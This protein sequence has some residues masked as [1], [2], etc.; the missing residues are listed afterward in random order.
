[1]DCLSLLPIDIFIKI[2]TYISFNDVKV[3][4]MTNKKLHNYCTNYNNRWKLLIYNTF[5][6]IDDYNNILK[7]VQN[8]LDCECD[9]LVYTKLIEY[10]DPIT[11]LMI[12]YRQNN[13][14]FDS[15]NYNAFQRFLSLFLLGEKNIVANYLNH[16][17]NIYISDDHLPILD[18]LNDLPVE[19][20]VL[21]WMLVEMASEGCLKG[22]KYLVSKGADSNNDIAC[23]CASENGHL[24]VV[25]Y[26]VQNGANIHANNNSAL[27]WA[28]QNGH[29]EI[30]KFLHK[31]GANIHVQDDK[32]FRWASKNGHL[33]VM[34]YLHKEGANIHADNDY[35]F[36]YANRNVHLPVVE[37]IVQNS[38]NIYVDKPYAFMIACQHGH[39]GLVKLY[40]ENGTD[41]HADYDAGLRVARLNRHADVIEYLI[42]N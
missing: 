17:G 19:K 37:Y 7:Q 5:S 35:A 32:A 26:L 18:L 4:C 12:Y 2:I 22:I 30:V 3:L 13:K 34:K 38:A 41:I 15:D 1:M 21:N 27:N 11:Q 39:L 42:Q 23:V 9:Y 6:S 24:P 20:D 33:D 28:S 16:E 25:E 40:H 14:L 10:L 29:L 8:D 31:E 36:K